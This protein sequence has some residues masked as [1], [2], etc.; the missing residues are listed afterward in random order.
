MYTTAL[1]SKSRSYRED[2]RVQLTNNLKD[3][4]Y[5]SHCIQIS[6]QGQ[7][8]HRVSAQYYYIGILVCLHLPFVEAG[9][10]PGN[11]HPNEILIDDMLTSMTRLRSVPQACLLAGWLTM[12]QELE[13]ASSGKSEV[14]MFTAGSSMASSNTVWC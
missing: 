6:G 9:R 2:T 4:P 3:I 11:S 12:T 10:I 1:N 8:R 14:S 13:D 5:S 7:H